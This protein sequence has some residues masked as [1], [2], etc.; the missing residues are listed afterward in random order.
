[1]FRFGQAL[2]GENQ[3][4]HQVLMVLHIAASCLFIPVV[5]QLQYNPEIIITTLQN[6][7]S[8]HPAEKILLY[9]RIG[10]WLLA[11][12]HIFGAI[13]ELRKLIKLEVEGFSQK[14]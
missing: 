3:R 6:I 11:V 4:I 7:F 5:L 13:D 1:I 12:G 14:G 2:A 9:V 10:S 8:S